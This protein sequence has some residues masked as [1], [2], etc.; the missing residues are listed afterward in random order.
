M[1]ESNSATV[2]IVALSLGECDLNRVIYIVDS[3]TMVSSQCNS[4]AV[5][6]YETNYACY[7]SK[8]KPITL[9]FVLTGNTKQ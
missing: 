2:M 5:K 4:S 3:R 6:S 9:G 1:Q 8:K 7:S